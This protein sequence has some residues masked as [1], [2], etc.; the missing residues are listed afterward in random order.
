MRQRLIALWWWAR[1]DF[2]AIFMCPHGRH[3]A[4]ASDPDGAMW[5]RWCI[6]PMNDAALTQEARDRAEKIEEP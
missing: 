2:R 6:E 4:G 1:H 5:C 3:V